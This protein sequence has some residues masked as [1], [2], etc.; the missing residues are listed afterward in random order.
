MSSVGKIN[1]YCNYTTPLTG[2]LLKT[3]HC[4]PHLKKRAMQITA[5]M[6][7]RNQQKTWS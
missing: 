7:E 1:V 2:R 3:A 5:M 4:D 6:L